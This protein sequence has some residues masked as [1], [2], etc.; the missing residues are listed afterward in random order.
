MVGPGLGE[1]RNGRAEEAWAEA[2]RGG[3]QGS[4]GVGGLKEQ[5]TVNEI[6]ALYEVHPV[7][8][9]QWKKQAWE[10]LA[11]L[12]S[13]GRVRDEKAKRPCGSGCT[14]RSAS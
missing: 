1:S 9:S 2:A 7:Q 13:R 6:A 12:F 8:V 3:L 11:E 10:G 14:R 5:G 4:G